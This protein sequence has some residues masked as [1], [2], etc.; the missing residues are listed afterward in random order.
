MLNCKQI[1]Q[2]LSDSQHKKLSLPT[3]IQLKLHL[4]GCIFCRRYQK[5]MQFLCCAL[6]KKIHDD[7]AALNPEAKER[8]KTRLEQ[9]TPKKD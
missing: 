7:T 5:R 3:R 8:I 1:S 4:L 2:L 6:E 9:N